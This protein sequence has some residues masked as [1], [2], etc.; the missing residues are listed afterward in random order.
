[1][2]PDCS[3]CFWFLIDRK[4]GPGDLRIGTCKG[5]NSDDYAHRILATHP[6]CD[7]DMVLSLCK[8]CGGAGELPYPNKE[9][10]QCP[11]CKGRGYLEDNEIVFQDTDYLKGYTISNSEEITMKEIPWDECFSLIQE[12]KEL[13]RTIAINPFWESY[14]SESS[15][16]RILTS[17]YMDPDL[18]FVFKGFWNIED[19]GIK[20]PE[21]I[22]VIDLKKERIVIKKGEIIV[23]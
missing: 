21:L 20:S 12:Q 10:I 17:K 11:V 7:G 2:K 19:L 5:E 16:I 1:M 14:F 3:T 13:Q 18:I 6:S 8:T 23:L 9:G 15:N 22:A 4:L